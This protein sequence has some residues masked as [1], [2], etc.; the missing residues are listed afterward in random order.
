MIMT[1]GDSRVGKSTV[2]KLLIDLLQSQNRKIKVYNHD[3]LQ[4]FKAY[5]TVVT[6]DSLDFFRG[7]TD[8]IL[9][10]LN[11]DELEIIM[12]DMPGQYLEK[13]CQYIQR[14]DLFSL[15]V[16]YQW[17]L[18]F[19]QPISQRIDCVN[20]L[21]SLLEFAID[22]T[23]YVLVKN[24]YFGEIFRDYQEIM[25]SKFRIIGGAE[26]ELT[27]LHRDHYEAIERT[28]KPISQ[29]VTDTSV[30]LVY[31]T[32]IYHWI[33]NFHASIRNETIASKYL[34]I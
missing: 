23:N 11:N 22:N 16:D 8:K 24:Q 33:K 9:Q 20:Y 32:Y 34:G 1:V 6:I 7:E 13:I 21:K 14:T 2:I 18:T 27:R 19:V 5:E 17:S 28:A 15:L 30:Y 12:V 4:R 26:I 10:D 31:R 3:N 29:C 25:Q